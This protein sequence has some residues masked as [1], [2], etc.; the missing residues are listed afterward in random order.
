MPTP[1]PPPITPTPSPSPAQPPIKR[2]TRDRLISSIK[3]GRSQGMTAALYIAMINY[4]GVDFSLTPEEEEEIRRS[5]DYLGKTGLD[6]L[7]IAIHNNY[8]LGAGS[9]PTDKGAE[10]KLRNLIISKREPTEE[11]MKEALLRTLVK[12]GGQRKDDNSIVIGNIIA[13][14][15][16]KIEKFEKLGCKPANYGAGYECTYNSTIS[17]TFNSNDGTE[18]GAQHAEAWNTLLRGFGGNAAN[19][20]VTRKFVQSKEG[21]IAFQD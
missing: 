21:W 13:G 17:Q 20:T 8:R 1:T 15:T 7:I 4:Y 2:I 6:S 3:L 9:S 19:E 18:R 16:I 11:E 10:E 12:R 5:G 14:I